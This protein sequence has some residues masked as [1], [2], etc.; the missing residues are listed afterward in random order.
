[1]NVPDDLRYSK[2]HEWAR[3][4]D[5]DGAIRVRVGITDYAQDALGDVVFVQLPEL[6]ASVT[7]GDSFGEIESTKSV[8]DIYA[9]VSGT[10]VEINDD[11]GDEPRAAE[12]RS[13][14]ERLGVRDRSG[15]QRGTGGPPRRDR[16]PHADR[17][18]KPERALHVSGIY[19][20]NC[21]HHNPDGANFCSSCGAP[22]ESSGTD[23]TLRLHAVDP[24]QDA[25]GPQD[26]VVVDLDL[27]VTGAGVLVVRS[28]TTPGQR[29]A[30]DRRLTRLGR[31]PQSDVTLDDITVS[32][33]HADIERL[34]EGGY[35]IRDAGSL[36]GTYVNGARV[37]RAVLANGDEVQIGKFRMLFLDALG[38][39][40]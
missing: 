36:N 40:A 19:C 18:L 1:M 26:D 16:V 34:A 22:L 38:G 4:E 37:E 11:P 13:L 31:H 17:G 12:H 6:G 9:P 7:V 20:T 32:R 24:S 33:R 10:V 14:R 2:D 30:L 29:L 8:S 23:R 21:G 3:I 28:G 25:P 27:E 35:E 15:G 5:S 39:Q